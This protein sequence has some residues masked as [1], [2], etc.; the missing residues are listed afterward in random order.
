MPAYIKKNNK[1]FTDEGNVAISG[2][3]HI[4]KI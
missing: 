2:P 3:C 1:R 4:S